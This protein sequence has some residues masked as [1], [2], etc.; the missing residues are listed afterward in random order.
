[1]A[2]EA[3]E[4]LSISDGLDDGSTVDAA[5]AE[6]RGDNFVPTGD[7]DDGGAPAAATAGGDEDGAEDAATGGKPRG[8]PPERFNEVTAKRREAEERAAQLAQE[9]EELRRQLTVG[10]PPAAAAAPAAAADADSEPAAFNLKATQQ[11]AADA[12]LEGDMERYTE[13]QSEIYAHI[14]NE[15]AAKAV[16]TTNAATAAA[17]Q[18]AEQAQEAAA[19]SAVATG[20]V[21]KYPFLH[22]ETG[23]PDAISDVVGWRNVYIGR[24]MKP[25]EA[26]A[27]AIDKV[28][29]DYGGE[30]ATATAKKPGVADPRPWAA[31][32][33]GAEMA[34][35]QPPIPN[36]GLG[37]RATA[38]KINVADL[39]EA[40][41]R[42]LSEADKKRLRGD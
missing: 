33:R 17:K 9:N 19:L 7:D 38:S 29:P 15:A 41:F 4:E 37:E 42:A 34:G 22:A 30:P 24:G 12:L 1:M 25:S 10:K 39:S 14:A 32:A 40:Q 36:G 31:A 35:G 13:L 6:A 27:K 18:E 3:I 28:V 23:N 5:K 11:A 16:Q 8:I 26:L 20:A 21:E 2:G